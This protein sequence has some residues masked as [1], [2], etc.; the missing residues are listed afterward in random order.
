MRLVCPNCSAQYEV[1]DGAIPDIGRN[2]QC[3]NCGDTWFQASDKAQTVT[4]VAPEPALDDD[5]PVP[6][7]VV[8]E[9][10]DETET[11]DASTETTFEDDDIELPEDD[12]QDQSPRAGIS[13]RESG[14]SEAPRVDPTVLD[15]LRR[16]AEIET[17]ARQSDA[18]QSTESAETETI[19]FTPDLPDDPTEKE[20]LGQRARATRNRVT[21][22]RDR[23]R[24]L[25]VS[26]PETDPALDDSLM[27]A[28]RRGADDR[29]GQLPDVE[30][31]NSTLR[32]ARDKSRPADGEDDIA[33][34]APS[35]RGRIGFYLAVLIALLMLAAYQLDR[36]IVE[37][38]P[39]TEPYLTAYVDGVNQ[40]RIWV[41]DMID[42]GIAAGR[43]LTGL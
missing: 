27:S 30:E 23:E 6:D 34:P 8:D 39:E 17:A 42:I 22:G 41:N 21:N 3:A 12:G 37:A 32:S 26:T 35:N 28:P 9:V 11:E 18:A 43:D 36:Q 1:D 24:R 19:D 40:G 31:L 25:N 13:H 10:V 7:E 5:R 29:A 14:T 33:A 38:I 2:V 4:D 16:E 15:I 20:S